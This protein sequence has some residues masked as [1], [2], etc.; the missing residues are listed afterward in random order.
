MIRR[1]LPVVCWVFFFCLLSA[2]ARAQIAP[3]ADAGQDQIVD[4]GTL[5]TLDASN[6][7][8]PDDGIASF[9]WLQTA[10]PVVTLSDSSVVQPTFVPDVGVSGATLEF[11]LTVTDNGGLTDVDYC[12]VTV[13]WANAAPIAD[14][15]P[16]Q[17]ASEGALVTLDGSGSS[18]SDDGIA[19]YYWTQIEGPSVTL[20]DRTAINPSFT[21]PNVQSS[22]VYLTFKLTVTDNGGL[23]G[24]DTCIVNVGW[25]QTAPV[26]N[27][28]PD[29]TVQEG[30]TVTLDGSGSYDPDDGIAAY[31]W[32]QTAGPQAVL[33]DAGAVT[34]SFIAPEA[35]ESGD[36]LTFQLTVTDGAGNQSA[37]SCN[38]TVSYV[39]NAPM[40][41]AGSD[42]SVNEGT[43]VQLDGS[44]ST[45]SDDGIAA[46][47]W[48]QTA[49]IPVELSDPSSATPT[50][51]A[52]DVIS[53]D[54]VLTFE[55]T[56][57]DRA[58][59]QG[60]DDVAVTV[61]WV[62]VRP[63]ADAGPDQ[64]VG[65]GV[66]VT[67]DAS[68]SSDED[69][70][71]MAFSWLQTSGMTVAL[72][73][74]AAAQP[75]F[76]T[77]EV[78][79]DGESLTFQLTVTDAG[80][81]TDTD[82]CIVNISWQNSAPVANAG[83]DQAVSEGVIVTLDGSGSSD[84][85]DGIAYYRWVQTSGPAATLSD[86]AAVSPTFIAPNVAAEGAA[87]TFQLTVT[88]SG[89]LASADGVTVTVAWLNQPP[90]TSA[91]P[92][93]TAAE[94]ETVMLDGS[95]SYDSDNGIAAYQWI[96]TGGPFAALSDAT[97]VQPELT[98]PDVGPGGASLVFQLT[99][100]DNDGLQ[101]S[102]SCIVNVTWINL[103]P[104][105]DAGAD[106]TV[107]KGETVI[108]D[109]S[110]SSGPDDDI[111]TYY[112]SQIEGTQVDLDDHYAVNPTFTAPD[113]GPDG[114]SL[115]FQLTVADSGGLQAT[116]EVIITVS[117][118]NSPPDADAGTDRAVEEGM[119]VTLDASQTSDPD[120]DAI[121]SYRWTQLS[122]RPVTLSHPASATATFVPPPVSDAET[123]GF[124]VTV[125]DAA[126]LQASDD[127]EITVVDNGVADYPADAVPFKSAD[128]QNMG[129]KVFNGNLTWLYPVTAA[130][131]EYT[132]NPPTEALYGFFDAGLRCAAGAVMTVTLYLPSPAP[133][134]YSLFSYSETDGW[135]PA[136]DAVFNDARNQIVFTIEDGGP[137]DGDGLADG[138]VTPVLGVGLPGADNSDDD[139]DAYSGGDD[140]DDTVCFIGSAGR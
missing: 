57:T 60:A 47:A 101:S 89:G 33:S 136:A 35:D 6:S 72:S 134:E 77:P 53:E 22:G 30:D 55:L 117:W 28:G 49:G 69:D 32:L 93:Q 64:T 104:E 130:E 26:A 29:Q 110:G 2:A 40:A 10:G 137:G 65:E 124:R 27:A 127:V 38:V 12:T 103:P 106:Q 25:V 116:D 67:L 92:D 119:T 51:V 133:Y 121:V 90:V 129:I 113:A 81:L 87:L 71:I 19:S 139:D 140:S 54:A 99:V 131:L 62:P 88:D 111:E 85:D 48:V 82:A 5:V 1:C 3:T 24:T 107:N 16:D 7:S 86:A 123:L 115:T 75:T 105:A 18:D 4:D 37:D 42:K 135:T 14:A 21:A 97:I 45:D 39:N 11:Q 100:T 83:E 80:G 68:G 63:A 50:F 9:K 98:T 84:P 23:Q 125:A 46:Y 13:V 79:P 94:G 91:G 74:P 126:G 36:V 76:V 109:G 114:E 34:P 31:K 20:S 52:P 78:G 70:G 102:D 73:D 56:V 44:G 66:T 132:G 108:L 96:Q 120:G 112:W 118:V 122:G 128:N 61:V 59:N 58:G 95:N 8:D 15:G 17:S 43:T 41:D 138:V